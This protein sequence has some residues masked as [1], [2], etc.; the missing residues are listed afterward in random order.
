[1]H[2]HDYGGLHED[3]KRTGAAMK[4]RD[5][6]RLAMGGVGMG[7]VYLF[8]RADEVRGVEGGGANC[9][10]I[11]EET[12]GPFPADGSNGPDVLSK[13]GVVRSDIRSSFAGL[14]GA[15]AGVPLTVML[16]LVELQ[17][18][19]APAA[20]L[21]VYVWHCD[22]AGLYSLYNRGA[23]DQNYLRGVQESD[24]GGEV[25]FTT[26]F[27]GCYRGR[28]PHIH[29]EIFRDLAAAADAGD[30]IAT[31][32]LA[33]PEAACAEVYGAQGYD[34]SARTFQR[35]SLTRDSVFRDGVDRQM[36]TMSGDAASGFAAELTIAV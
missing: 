5:V 8:G 32:Q 18:G 4:R 19:C 22:A 17:Q 29:F 23:T 12:A 31:S 3:L 13:A 27:P 25:S 11:P 20:G 10:K 28:W 16:Q 34:A 36:A 24:A 6:L 7:A 35:A 9:E 30:K 2:H 14:S 15:A 33:F 1:M 26:I 21:A